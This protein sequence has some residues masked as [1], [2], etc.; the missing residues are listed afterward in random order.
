MAVSMISNHPHPPA[1]PARATLP[2]M[3]KPAAWEYVAVAALLVL[4]GWAL[5]AYARPESPVPAPSS[6]LT[7]R[8]RAADPLTAAA[9]SEP[10]QHHVPVRLSQNAGAYVIASMFWVDPVF[11]HA[12]TIT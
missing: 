2:A 6:G 3:T 7:P 10:I 12:S 4:L 1:A 11:C 9:D 8:P 5:L